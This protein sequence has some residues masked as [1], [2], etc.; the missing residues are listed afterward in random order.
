MIDRPRTILQVLPKLDAGGAERVA[1][2]IAEAVRLAGHRSI[3]AAEDGHLSPLAARAGVEL[4]HLDLSTKNP[5]KI[6]KNTKKLKLILKENQVDLVHAHSRAP[7]WSAY[8]A[9]KSEGVFFVT[10]YHGTYGESS[11]LKKRYNQVMAAGD[12]VVAVSNFIADL[13]KARYNIDFE[14]IRV[15]HNGVDLKKFDPEAVRG[16]RAVR[17][18]K[19]WRIENGAPAI[20]LPA[21]LTSWKG[22]RLFIHALAKMRHGEA[23]GILIGSDQG[24]HKYTEELLALAE[25]LGVGG[26][27][28]LAGHVEDMPAALKLADIVVNCS[29][30]PEAFGRTIIEAQAMG[31]IVVAAGHGGAHETIEPNVSGFLFPP[32]DDTA[33]AAIFDAI[34][35]GDADLRLAFGAHAREEVGARFSLEAMQT[36]YLQLYA[37]LLG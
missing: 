29:T 12:R 2:E 16:D 36:R 22:Q 20:L 19:D 18:A 24:R 23:V 1:I 7:A 31:K 28:R 37:E 34:L 17:L 10:T 3:I 21:R 14:K 13:I 8:R 33:L 25:R 35:E 9:A 15:I 27:L 26:R 5:L 11:R 32:G 6:W 30:E 4:I